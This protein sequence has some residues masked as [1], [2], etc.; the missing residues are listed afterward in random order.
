MSSK[1]GVLF[2][3]YEINITKKVI[4][5]KLYYLKSYLFGFFDLYSVKDVSGQLIH[6][7]SG[8]LK[9]GGSNGN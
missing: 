7:K 3:V 6:V 9:L 5:C 4:K 1:A 2:V 8:G